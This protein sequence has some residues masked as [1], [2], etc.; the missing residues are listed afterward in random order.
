MSTETDAYIERFDY[1]TDEFKKALQ[2]ISTEELDWAPLSVDANS[3]TV[4][5]THVAGTQIGWVHQVVGGMDITRDRD[6]EFATRGATLDELEALLNRT[7]STTRTVIDGLSTAD[8]HKLHETADGQRV[9][10]RW[11]ILHTLEHIGQHLGH[12][13]LTRQLYAQKNG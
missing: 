1:L 9:T 4:L 3:A 12:L 6:A 7:A 10:T 2:G 11:A 13:T 8:L 5:T